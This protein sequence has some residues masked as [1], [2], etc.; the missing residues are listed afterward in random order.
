MVGFPEMPFALASDLELRW[1]PL[2]PGERSQADVLLEDASQLIVDQCP[3]ASAASESTLRRV[4][5]SVVKR[6][7]M[8]PPILGAESVQQGGGGYQASVNFV[9]PSG[10]L[11][12]SKSEKQSL[13]CG[14]QRAFMIDLAASAEG[15]RGVSSP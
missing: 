15:E 9:N 14:R 6:A 7:M 2:T 3:A 11:Y 12:L 4:A 5:C 13:G 10:D 1:K 8:A